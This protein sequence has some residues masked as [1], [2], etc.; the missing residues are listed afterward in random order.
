MPGRRA[1]RGQ[2][3][4]D[5]PRP[6]RIR[7]FL[8]PAL[9]L[10]LHCDPMHGYALVEGLR[11][12]G[13]ESYATDMSA[14]Y[15][16]LYSLEERGMLASAQSKEASGGPPRRVYTLT[17][18][19]DAF[20]HDWVVELRET[21]RVLHSFLEAYDSHQVLH[22]EEPQRGPFAAVVERHPEE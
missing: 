18:A 4:G 1:R 19:G 5:G 14:I 7:R 16:V 8:E 9:L 20:L 17:P 12:L 3:R 11:D 10:L 22:Q 2:T 15:R 13:L 21:D 6:R